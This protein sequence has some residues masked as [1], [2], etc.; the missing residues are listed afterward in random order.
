MPSIGQENLE[1]VMIDFLG[2]LRRGDFE[3]AAGLLDPDVS[4]QGLREEWVC[5]GRQ[6][7]VDTFRWGLERR[8]EIDALEFSR[9]GEQVV[10]GARGPNIGPEEEPLGQISTSSRCATDRSCASTTT[11]AAGRRSPQPVS[12]RTRTGADQ[13]RGLSER[14]SCRAG[15]RRQKRTPVS[16]SGGSRSTVPAPPWGRGRRGSRTPI[17]G[18]AGG[19]SSHAVGTVCSQRRWKKAISRLKRFGC[20]QRGLSI[21]CDRSRPIAAC[22]PASAA[23]EERDEALVESAG[24]VDD[25]A[26][27]REH[28][29]RLAP[30]TRGLAEG[31]VGVPD[32]VAGPAEAAGRVVCEPAA[33][34]AGAV[35]EADDARVVEHVRVPGAPRV[36][37][38]YRQPDRVHGQLRVRV[39][40]EDVRAD[41]TGPER[42]DASG[43]RDEQ[44][45]AWLAG[46]GVEQRAQLA[47][48]TQVG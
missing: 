48:V 25:V 43:G 18:S 30:P 10:L 34:E 6:E 29:A 27:A 16:Y 14:R 11:G 47:D 8:R 41:P 40:V 28:A 2:A 1:T 23:G 39:R 32:D 35:P 37:G 9:G 17:S 12:P 45:Q 19:S 15:R 36:A 38:K 5:H 46:A 21:A 22:A 33:G 4:W 13:A 44:D 31:Q 42:A 26:A 24:V 20:R 7:V 3:A